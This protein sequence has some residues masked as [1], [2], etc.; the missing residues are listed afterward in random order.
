MILPYIIIRD[1]QKAS[2]H[3]IIVMLILGQGALASTATI[4]RAPYLT[5]CLATKF[6]YCSQLYRLN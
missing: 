6:Y 5:Y 3:K 2:R 4:V 1:L